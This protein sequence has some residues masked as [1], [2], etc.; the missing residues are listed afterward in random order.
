MINTFTE[1]PQVHM[2]TLSLWFMCLFTDIFTDFYKENIRITLT[3]LV[4][5]QGNFNKTEL[6]F[7]SLHILTISYY[8]GHK[9]L[10]Q[11][12]KKSIVQKFYYFIMLG[13]TGLIN[14]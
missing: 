14:E 11:L 6:F 3:L 4:I 13:F 9:S 7:L 12:K 1:K 8:M 10:D 5:F 2:S